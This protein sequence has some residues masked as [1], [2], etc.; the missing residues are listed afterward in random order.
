LEPG[1]ALTHAA[2]S[3]EPM[4]AHFIAPAGPAGAVA[5][6]GSSASAKISAGILFGIIVSP[7]NGG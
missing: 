5:Q 7:D 3:L 4:V 6:A 2:Q 1:I